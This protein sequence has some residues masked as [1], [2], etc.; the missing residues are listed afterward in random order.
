[1]N[2]QINKTKNNIDG[3]ESKCLYLRRQ[4]GEPLKI[5]EISIELKNINNDGV[6]MAVQAPRHI[7][8]NKRD[9]K[10]EKQAGS[11]KE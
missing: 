6:E 8:I 10:H 7:R 3:R 11:S 4:F 2:K 5:G 1:M 9:D